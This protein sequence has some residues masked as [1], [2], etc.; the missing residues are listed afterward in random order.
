MSQPLPHI[1]IVDDLELSRKLLDSLL[2][3][4]GEYTTTQAASG[5]EALARCKR[6]RPDLVLLDLMMPE[7]DG[8]ETLDRLLELPDMQDVPVIFVSA[9]EDR[10]DIVRG[11]E[12]GAMDFV[13]RPVIPEILLARIKNH[14]RIGQTLARLRNRNQKIEEAARLLEQVR[15]EG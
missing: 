5:A 4:T 10:D 8:I 6:T 11:L 3:K 14:L 12:H 15:L 7:M 2:A 1:L 13:T 9:S